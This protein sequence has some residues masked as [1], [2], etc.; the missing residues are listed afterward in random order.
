MFSSLLYSCEA[1][2]NIDVIAEKLMLIEKKALKRCLGVKKGTTDDI[3]YYEI[4]RADLV[5]VITD[6]QYKFFQKICLF[7]QDEA[8]VKY[9][10]DRF[11]EMN[12]TWTRDN[13]MKL[14]DDNVEINKKE[15]RKRINESDKT[16][17]KTYNEITSLKEPTLLYSSMINDLDRIVITRW[18]LSSHR[19]HIETGR[20][21]K[22]I[23]AKEDRLCSICRT[24]EN[25]DH[26]LFKCTAHSYIR[27]RYQ[28]LCDK[29]PTVDKILNPQLQADIK[30]VAEYIREIERNMEKLKMIQ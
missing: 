28:T 20:Y 23:V 13:F 25:E 9:I 14:R 19:L 5:A 7:Q 29:Y 11:M 15:R 26:A 16:M 21:K 6:R 1:W 12:L 27:I 8:I 22:P 3:V 30:K 18:R 24:L 17:C 10:V 2:G 4:N